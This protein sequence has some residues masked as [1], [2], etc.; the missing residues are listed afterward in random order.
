MLEQA[1]LELSVTAPVC[2]DPQGNEAA[3]ARAELAQNDFDVLIV[4]VAG[5]IP[6]WAVFSV[7]EPFKHKPMVLWGLSGWQDGDRFVTTADQAGTTALRK[8]MEDMGYKFRYV[9]TYRG[10]K[11]KTDEIVAYARSCPRGVPASKSPESAWRVT[12]IC[13]CTA[14]FMTAFL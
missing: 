10:Q 8:P 4:C 12:A 13:G 7:I 6:S 2:D 5:W 3:R 1:G 14:R 11:P 9:V